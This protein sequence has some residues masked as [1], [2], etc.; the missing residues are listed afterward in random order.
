MAPNPSVTLQFTKWRTCYD[1][2]LEELN[3]RIRRC[4]KCRLWKNAE[5]A[6][7]GEGPSDA[8]VMLVGQNPGKAEDETG[9]PFVGRA[10]GFLN[11]ILNK[12]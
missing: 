11:K 4:E 8:R 12:N 9:K 5:N 2:T 1:L 6:V 7:P 3:R 10:G